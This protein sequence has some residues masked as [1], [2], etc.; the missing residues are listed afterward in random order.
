MKSGTT[1]LV[2]FTPILLGHFTGC[3]GGGGGGPVAPPAATSNLVQ[4]VALANFGEIYDCIPR[5]FNAEDD[6]S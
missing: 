2:L 4:M 3:G 5:T 6:G 1:Y